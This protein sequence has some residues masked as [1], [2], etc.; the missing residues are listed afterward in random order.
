MRQ[1][2]KL[3][4][5]AFDLTI[6]RLLNELLHSC[7]LREV[8]HSQRA[9]KHKSSLRPWFVKCS[10]ILLCG[11]FAAVH[12]MSR[13]TY[14][15]CHCVLGEPTDVPA[16]PLCTVAL[17]TGVSR[18]TQSSPQ[19]ES[20]RD[21]STESLLNARRLLLSSLPRIMVGMAALW[22]AITAHTAR[23]VVRIQQN[24]RLQSRHS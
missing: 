15:L 23:W 21:T 20:G 11:L 4:S 22:H 18:L 12:W 2:Q 19:D 6:Q 8:Y 3:A 9:L 24:H 13:R 10:V 14:L 7:G 5:G 17:C 1:H 16:L